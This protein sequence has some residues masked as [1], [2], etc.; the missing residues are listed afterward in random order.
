MQLTLLYRMQFPK[1]DDN[2]YRDLAERLKKQG[3]AREEPERAGK[4]KR[5]AVGSTPSACSCFQ[6]DDRVS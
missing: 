1:R 6:V 2:T 5:A 4:K 3:P